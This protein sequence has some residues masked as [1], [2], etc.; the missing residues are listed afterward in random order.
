MTH[1]EQYFKSLRFPIFLFTLLSCCLGLA[2][3]QAISGNLVGTV[4]DPT[5]AVVANAEVTATNVGTS[6]SAVTHTNAT[7]EY[8]FDNLPVGTYKITVKAQGFRSVIEQ[9]DVVLNKTGTL[10]AKVVPGAASETVEVSG[11]APAIDTTTAQL[12]S[13]YDPQYAQDLGLTS[14]GGAGAGVLNLS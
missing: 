1:V 10:N 12:Q 14:A 9:A 3:G 5:G 6:A 11:A 13:I 2:F 4:T 8:R 7:G